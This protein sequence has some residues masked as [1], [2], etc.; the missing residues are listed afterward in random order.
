MIQLTENRRYRMLRVFTLHPGE[1]SV[2]AF[3]Q[4][5]Q[6]L[7]L[8]LAGWVNR[9]QQDVITYLITENRVLRRKLGRKRILL[10]DNQRR[11]LGVKGKILGRKILQE[12]ASVRTPDMILRWHRELVLRHWDFSE[13]PRNECRRRGTES[14]K[15]VPALQTSVLRN[16]YPRADARGYYLPALRAWSHFN[17]V[18]RAYFLAVAKAMA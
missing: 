7:L 17:F 16:P 6:L 8:I 14:A 15:L 4:P 3:L 1:N 10:N 5:R 18:I 13:S 2:K 12:I 9:G 11:L